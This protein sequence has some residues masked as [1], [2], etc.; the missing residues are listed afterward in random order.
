MIGNLNR[1]SLALVVAVIRNSIVCG[2]VT[3][4]CDVVFGVGVNLGRLLGL[5]LLVLGQIVHAHARPHCVH[6]HPHPEQHRLPCAARKPPHVPG[7]P[8]ATSGVALG[9]PP[10]SKGVTHR[11]P[12]FF[13]FI[14]RIYILG[15]IFFIKLLFEGISIFKQNLT[16]KNNIFRPI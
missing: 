4:T 7:W 12:F 3:S 2:G 13:F 9:Y 15:L 1:N 14:F 10:P 5:G 6:H 8:R 16:S 11:P